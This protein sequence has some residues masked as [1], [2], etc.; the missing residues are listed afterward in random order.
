[1]SLYLFMLLIAIVSLLLIL[2]IMVQN[3]KGGGLDSSFGGGGGQMFGGV[4]ETT[5]FLDKA[6]WYLFGLLVI[7]ILIS[8]AVLIKD[9]AEESSAVKEAVEQHVQDQKD[10]PTKNPILNNNTPVKEKAPTKN[11]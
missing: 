6:T 5:N 4:Q 1:M 8:N 10:I 11:K 2:M 9:K 3:P 7:L